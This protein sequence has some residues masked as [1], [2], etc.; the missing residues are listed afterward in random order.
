M[1]ATERRLGF[2]PK[3]AVFDA[4]FD[5]FYIYDYFHSDDHDGF[6]AI[7]FSDRGGYKRTFDAQGLP[8]CQAGLPMPLKYAFQ[9]KSSL[10]EHERGRYVCPLLF[11]TPTGQACPINHHRWPKGGCTT[12]M[13]TSIGARLRY[14]LDRDSQAYKQLY[15]QRTVSE[16][17]NSQAVELG[18]ECPKIRNGQ[19]IANINTLIYVLI[20]LRTLQRIRQRK[21]DRRTQGQL[22]D[23][24]A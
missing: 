10:F 12:T 14:Q 18:I 7:P 1:A 2:R 8:V 21:A 20:N 6:A 4:A 17:I 23:P 5:A 19:A 11:S 24:T 3:F 16:R 13:A 15:N 9:A 22:P